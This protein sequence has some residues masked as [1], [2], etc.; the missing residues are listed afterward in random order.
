MTARLCSILL[1]GLLPLSLTAQTPELPAV[2]TEWPG[3]SYEVVR[4]ERLPENRLL[5]LFQI[6]AG[7]GAA[8]KGTFVGVPTPI[9]PNANPDDIRS[10][11]YDPKPF[12]IAATTMIDETTGSRYPALPPVAPPH[13]VYP[14]PEVLVTLAPGGKSRMLSLQFQAPPALPDASGKVPPQS[15]SFLLPKAKGAL[16]RVPVPPPVAPA[17]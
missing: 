1:L 14:Y 11:R 9:P 5:V 15:V 10:G 12:S 16:T 7:K 2:A 6:A 13:I 4:I 17:S 8:P 3:V